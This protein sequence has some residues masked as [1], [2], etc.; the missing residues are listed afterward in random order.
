[1][2]DYR[3]NRGTRP[4]WVLI[5]WELLKISVTMSC[6]SATLFAL[7]DFAR[8]PRFGQ[9]PVSFHS[10]GEYAARFRYLLDAQPTEEPQLDNLSLQRVQFREFR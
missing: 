6:C 8:K 2:D 1:M 3:V 5:E 10:C 9:P 4:R 7:L